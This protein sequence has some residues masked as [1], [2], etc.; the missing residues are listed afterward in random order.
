MPAA[1]F[2]GID[3]F[4]YTAN[5]GVS[6]VD[7]LTWFFAHSLL[8]SHAPIPS[9]LALVYPPA[10]CYTATTSLFPFAVMLSVFILACLI[11]IAFLDPASFNTK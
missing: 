6:N 8:C 5:N 10:F 11:P 7:G 2:N 3:S 9:S 4:T 1:N